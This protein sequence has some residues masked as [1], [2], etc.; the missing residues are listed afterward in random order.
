MTD[1]TIAELTADLEQWKRASRKWEARAKATQDAT[2]QA[3][4]KRLARVNEKL[5]E[6]QADR[7]AFS[8]S[9]RLWEERARTNLAVIRAHETTIAKFIDKLDDVLSEEDS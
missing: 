7:D 9:A 4:T 3:I 8:R 6:A 1:R 5:R 2:D